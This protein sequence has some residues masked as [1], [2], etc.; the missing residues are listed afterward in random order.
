VLECDQYYSRDG[1][2]Q[3][4]I[5]QPLERALKTYGRLLDAEFALD[6]QESAMLRG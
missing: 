4:T 5:S 6:Q 2:M 1:V 3:L